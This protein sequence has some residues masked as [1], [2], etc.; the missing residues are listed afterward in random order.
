[1]SISAVPTNP[2]Q[3]P[4]EYLLLSRQECDEDV[5]D[6]PYGEYRIYNGRL[7]IS[8]DV[9]LPHVCVRTG[10]VDDLLPRVATVRFASQCEAVVGLIL[11]LVTLIGGFFA[12][13]LTAAAVSA[14]RWPYPAEILITAFLAFGF[15]AG[16][17]LETLLRTGALPVT[18]RYFESASWR[19]TRNR[20][21]RIRL[22]ILV[23]LA[24]VAFAYVWLWL[25]TPVVFPIALYV[26]GIAASARFVVAIRFRNCMFF[27]NGI[28]VDFLQD[29]PFP[30][31]DA[32]SSATPATDCCLQK[33]VATIS[34][35]PSDR[36]N[37]QPKPTACCRRSPCIV[38]R[39]QAVGLGS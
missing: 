13:C 38:P 3:A 9:Q 5:D 29:S 32:R 22:Y 31:L 24:P 14:M 30:N 4:T 1:M 23:G 7:L 16:W 8:G 17:V 20:R 28:P 35:E 34:P 33:V 21:N 18:I 37:A 39:Q 25:D 10:V 15:A 11:A 6:V 2:F 26:A 19:A 36:R 12:V 27:I